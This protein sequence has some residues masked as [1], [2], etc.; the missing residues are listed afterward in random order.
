MQ[1]WIDQYLQLF[2][3]RIARCQQEIWTAQH[4][5]YIAYCEEKAYLDPAAYPAR[6]ET[7]ADDARSVHALLHFKPTGAPIG[8]VRLI[9]PPGCF[10]VEQ[11]SPFAIADLTED[12]RDRVAEISRLCMTWRYL[13][14]IPESLAGSLV[15]DRRRIAGYA[16]LGLF[17]GI[18][19]LS[20]ECGVTYWCGMMSPAVLRGG[21]RLGV[22]F[23]E[24]GAP[25]WCFGRKQPIA[26]SVDEV[27]DTMRQERPELWALAAK[28]L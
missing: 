26:G 6:C 8:S 4:L 22:H 21:R 9:L 19:A 5:R 11:R 18:I 12:D 3:T 15:C 28:P 14:E 16:I 27:L 25:V 7:D 1:T 20:Q 13:P 10:P 17:R 2:E 24:R 23:K